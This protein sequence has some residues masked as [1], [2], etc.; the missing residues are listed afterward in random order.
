MTNDEEDDQEEG[1]EYQA[2]KKAKYAGPG[3]GDQQGSACT[4]GYCAPCYELA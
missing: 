1:D 4:D 3:D 2:T